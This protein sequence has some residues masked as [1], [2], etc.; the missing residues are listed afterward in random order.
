MQEAPLSATV[1]V[2]DWMFTARGVNENEFAANVSLIEQYVVA[3]KGAAAPVAAPT[4]DVSS[5]AQAVDNLAAA[6]VTATPVAQA[7]EERTDKFGNRFVKGDPGVPSCIHGQRVVAYKTSKAGKPYKAY[8]CVNDSP[9]GD[10][11]A[12]KCQQEYPQG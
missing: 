9:F 11:K 2:G 1:R 5:V 10:Y 12:G 4:Q 3:F 6:G 7:L 8:A